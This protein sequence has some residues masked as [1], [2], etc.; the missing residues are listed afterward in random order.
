MAGSGG[1]EQGASTHRASTHRA[2]GSI[3]PGCA[4]Q[5][6]PPAGCFC[7]GEVGRHAV[8]EAGQG[9]FSRAEQP[10]FPSCGAPASIV[11]EGHRLGEP[12]FRYWG[13]LCV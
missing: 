10:S 9:I 2:W 11:R 4:A 12:L 8:P 7:R 6:L 1:R 3:L 5:A 13:I